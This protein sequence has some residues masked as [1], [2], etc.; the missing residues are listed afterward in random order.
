MSKVKPGYRTTEFA[1]L[2]G[3]G[4]LFAFALYMV[5]ND[6]ITEDFAKWVMTTLAGGIGFGVREYIRSRGFVKGMANGHDV[7]ITD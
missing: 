5:G 3:L 4:A 1:V 7:V 2:V 6:M